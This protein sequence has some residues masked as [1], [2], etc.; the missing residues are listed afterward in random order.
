MDINAAKELVVKA[1]KSLVESGLIARTWGNV[2][3]RISDYDFVITPSGRDYISL[4]TDEIVTVKISDCSYSGNIKPSSEK[5]IHAEVYSL[6][7]EANFVIHTHQKN[8]SVV[9]ACGLDS[10]EVNENLS[11]F[12]SEVICASYA[13]P[14]TKK[15]R[16]NVKAA[17]SK[18]KGKAVIMK[19]HGA[20][21]F[22]KDYDEA[23]SVACELEKACESFIVRQYLKISGRD[24]LDINEMNSYALTALSK[25]ADKEANSSRPFYNSRRTDNGFELYNESGVKIE[26]L[27]NKIEHTL[28]AEA[29]I[30]NAIFNKYRNIN[31]I[32]H[33]TAAEIKALS[34]SG[35]ELKPFL[36]DFAQIAGTKARN[37]KLDTSSILSALRNS[38]VV[39]IQ[40][41][42]A[43]CCG[44]TKDDAI[45]AEMV[46]QKAS[47]AFLGT[48]LLGRGKPIK[49]LECLLM[50]FVYLYKY[51]KQKYLNNK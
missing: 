19:N 4:T 11:Y 43:L 17:L 26:V 31:Y 48:L 47:K 34:S 51:S 14:G 12:G 30:Y 38:S 16:R 42:G 24:V 9:S 15:L 5:G 50:R 44:K 39:L 28:P 41:N 3:C 35:S 27:Q 6:Y 8:A 7:P 22:G 10:M 21:C 2:S 25:A 23:F 40:N 46:T 13:L 29:E 33:S 32:I 36:D 18:S 45:A 20:L 1:G 49:S 37:V